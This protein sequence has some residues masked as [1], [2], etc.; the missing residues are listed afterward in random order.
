[1]FNLRAGTIILQSSTVSIE[2]FVLVDVVF[3]DSNTVPPVDSIKCRSSPGALGVLARCLFD[4]KTSCMQNL[5][6]YIQWTLSLFYVRVSSLIAAVYK[7]NLSCVLRVCFLSNDT[8]C[9]SIAL[10]TAGFHVCTVVCTVCVTSVEFTV[11]S[12]IE[13]L[14]LFPQ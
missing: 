3:S 1:M 11:G 4:S 14:I 12:K 5:K 13:E 8:I 10:Y 6:V 2:L 9:T 7:T